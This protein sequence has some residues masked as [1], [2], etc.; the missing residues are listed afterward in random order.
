VSYH[1]LDGRSPHHRCNIGFPPILVSL[2]LLVR[3]ALR[4]VWVRVL[5]LFKVVGATGLCGTTAGSPNRC[6]VTLVIDNM[7]IHKT[8][9]FD[10]GGEPLW[11]DVVQL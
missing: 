4:D 10:S 2:K 11:N 3:I 6:Y 8:V 9:V 1:D 7:E 5:T